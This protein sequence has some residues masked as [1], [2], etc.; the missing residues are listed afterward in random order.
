MGA[1]SKTNTTTTAAKWTATILFCALTVLTLL[2]R[3]NNNNNSSAAVHPEVGR[4]RLEATNNPINAEPTPY[5]EDLF[6]DLQARKKLFDD[7][8]AQEIKYWFEYSGALQVWYSYRRKR[9]CIVIIAKT[10]CSFSPTRH[11]S[12][13]K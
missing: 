11:H 3:N 10:T 1:T 8:P 2:V 9:C 13:I 7:T 12:M 6:A 4:R 5:M